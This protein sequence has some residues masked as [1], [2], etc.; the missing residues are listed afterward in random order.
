[1]VR[2]DAE[3]R[4]VLR[5]IPIFGRRK[6]VEL[7]IPKRCCSSWYGATASGGRN[8]DATDG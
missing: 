1:M 2:G 8:I 4:F 3:M 6:F 7:R 5:N